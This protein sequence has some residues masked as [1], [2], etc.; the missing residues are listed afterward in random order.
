MNSRVTLTCV[1]SLVFLGS[2]AA[3]G[4]QRKELYSLRSRQPASSQRT[5]ATEP[6]PQAP[7]VTTSIP[8]APL[9]EQEKLERLKLRAE[10]TRLR[11]RQQQLAD[12][13]DNNAQLLAKL[14]ALN[15]KPGT[16]KIALPDGYVRASDSRMVGFATPEAAFQS[17][18]WAFQRWDTNVLAQ[19]A[20]PE[21]FKYLVTSPEIR[22]KASK[23]PGY[24][25]RQKTSLPDGLIELEV[26]VVPGTPPD[27]LHLLLE[28]GQWKVTN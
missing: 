20:T 15:L 21:F 28:D 22:E 4:V 23:V 11:Q 17:F 19:A 16:D 3:V 24:L 27:K 25:I 2:L 26:E 18:A 12:V 5:A 1:L 13:K 14:T 6:R 8:S 10:V 9:T 7:P